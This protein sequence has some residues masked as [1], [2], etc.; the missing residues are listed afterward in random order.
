VFHGGEI[1]FHGCNGWLSEGWLFHGK[2]P[3]NTERAQKGSICTVSE[4]PSTM[5]SN[6]DGSDLNFASPKL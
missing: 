5:N 3:A 1:V 2:G 6:V 4:N